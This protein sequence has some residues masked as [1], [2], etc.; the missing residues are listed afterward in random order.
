M[1]NDDY[2]ANCQVKKISHE[3]FYFQNNKNEMLKNV[4]KAIPDT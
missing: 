2:V 3:I 1:S 4:K